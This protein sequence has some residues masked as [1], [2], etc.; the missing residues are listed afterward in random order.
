MPKP[1]RY[2]DICKLGGVRGVGL[3]QCVN[4]SNMDEANLLK[5][6]KNLTITNVSKSEDSFGDGRVGGHF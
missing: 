4:W 2:Y 1:P 5:S 6:L 3:G